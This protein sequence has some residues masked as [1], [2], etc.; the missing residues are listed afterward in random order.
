M[1]HSDAIRDY[2]KSLSK[3]LSRLERSDAEE[4]IR[5]I[6]SHILDVLEQQEQSGQD[7]DIDSILERFGPARELATQYV[8]HVRVGAPPPAGFR[9][10][11][12][13][14]QGVTKGIYYSMVAFGY[15][16][17]LLLFAAGLTKLFAPRQIGVWAASHGNSIII[18]FA[19]LGIANSNELLGF[20]L[21]PIALLLGA[22]IAS[23]TRRVLAVLKTK[24]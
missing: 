7:V 5:E 21:V 9:A 8:D 12:K 10:I 14:K 6:E 3:Y 18:S 19:D 20:W 15:G 17:A 24:A 16:T 13:V 4:V 22:G 23:L 11:Q 1:K 2:L